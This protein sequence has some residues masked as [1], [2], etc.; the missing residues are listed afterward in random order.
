MATFA[1]VFNRVKMSTATT[2]TGT[3][4][5]GSASSGYLTAS[6]AGVADGDYVSYVIEEGND[7]EIGYGTYTASGTTLARTA[8][9]VSKISGTAGTSKMN[10]A[11]AATV[12]LVPVARGLTRQIARPQGRLTLTANTPVMTATASGQTTIRYTPYPGG[13]GQL[14]PLWDGND[15]YMADIGGE[16]TQATTDST[17]SPA[18]AT[19]NSNYDMFVW[20][21]SGTLRCTRGPAWSSDTSRGTGAGT[22]EL[23]LVNGIYV[24]KNAI[25]NGPAAR[26]GTYVGTVR[27]NG[28][29][30][31]DWIYGAAASSGTA[32]VFGV[33]NMYNRVLVSSVTSDNGSSYTYNSTTWRAARASN[34]MRCSLVRGM[35]EDIVDA[36][37]QVTM[38]GG[39]SGDVQI[40]IGLDSTSANS[41]QIA[42]YFSLGTAVGAAPAAYAGYPGL[43]FHYLQALEH[44]LATAT[45]AGFYPVVGASDVTSGLRVVT[46][47]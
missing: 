38:N 11:G 15:F 24:N 16:L 42:P 14:V 12:A 7:F 25:T 32:G 10:L 4:T 40:G 20:S 19:T 35:D 36:L 43:G 8:V 29:S 18:A 3:V 21:D 1:K 2:G 33:W 47:A 39:A 41:A 37:Y 17:K 13:G 30:Q 26:R 28:S 34:T 22:T 9:E 31:I 6:E 5:L 27:S 46:M 23:E 44:Q 45:A